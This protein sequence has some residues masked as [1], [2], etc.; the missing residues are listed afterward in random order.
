VAGHSL[1]ALVAKRVF[2]PGWVEWSRFRS[3][4]VRF[5]TWLATMLV[6]AGM[7]LMAVTALPMVIVEPKKETMQAFSEPN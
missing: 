4:V 6:M 3:R 5:I 2:L 1:V 7:T